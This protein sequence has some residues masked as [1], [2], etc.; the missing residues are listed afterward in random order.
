MAWKTQEGPH[1]RLSLVAALQ[2]RRE[3]WFTPN[4]ADPIYTF[5]PRYRYHCENYR[6]DDGVFAV[7]NGSRLKVMWLPI[8]GNPEGRS[9]EHDLSTTPNTVFCMDPMQDM[10]AMLE[11]SNRVQFELSG[12]YIQNPKLEISHNTLVLWTCDYMPRVLIRRTFVRIMHWSVLKSTAADT[13]RQKINVVQQVL[14]VELNN[15]WYA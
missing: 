1:Q 9:I 15:P 2:R 10:I 8:A 11:K 4:L 14:T 5:G 6:L 7:T 12:R 3:A 13:R